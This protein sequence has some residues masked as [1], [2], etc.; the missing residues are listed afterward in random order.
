[1][2]TQCRVE[3]CAW[4]WA[5]LVLLKLQSPVHGRQPWRSSCCSRGQCGYAASHV[6]GGGHW[7][8]C[9]ASALSLRSTCRGKH[10]LRV[11]ALCR[12]RRKGGPAAL[13]AE[14]QQSHSSVS[15]LEDDLEDS[16]SEEDEPEILEPSSPGARTGSPLLG[17]ASCAQLA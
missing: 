14:Q 11:S 17:T 3:I 9:C 15:E 10:K 12:R 6:V 7:A 5:P 13:L 16:E 8:S 4:L 1:M 2:P